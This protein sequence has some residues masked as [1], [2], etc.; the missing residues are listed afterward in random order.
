LWSRKI[1]REKKETKQVTKI[2]SVANTVEKQVIK[3]DT[4]DTEETDV[5]YY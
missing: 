2:D 4:K 1:E 3:I 5:I